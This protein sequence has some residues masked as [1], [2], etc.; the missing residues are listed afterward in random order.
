MFE[1]DKLAVPS[2][3]LPCLNH[4]WE[5][6]ES[7][8][9]QVVPDLEEAK[10][11][12]FQWALSNENGELVLRNLI[13]KDLDNIKVDFASGAMDYR[14]SHGQGRGELLA[15]AI[16]IKKNNI[17]NVLD[18]TAGL[19]RDSFFLASLGCQVTM[20]ERSPVIASLL[21]DG[22]NRAMEKPY[23]VEITQ[24]ISLLKKDALNYLKNLE[25]EQVSG[26]DC[27]Y[28]DPMFPENKKSR[29]VKK[30]MRALANLLGEDMDGSEL[31]HAAL[32]SGVHRMIVKRHRND[33]P[34]G[35]TEPAL[36]FKGK[37]SRFDVYFHT[38]GQIAIKHKE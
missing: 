21:Q 6:D 3:T 10:S 36:K 12:G 38:P 24:R 15:R 1:L 34:L 18:L 27:I 19:G 4:I 7:P 35:N 30:E 29:L 8:D 2:I 37:S 28:L 16:G 23:L 5:F 31:F 14:R 26:F 13:A 17:P 11:M 22:I 20:L 33:P 25:A 9:W 32:S